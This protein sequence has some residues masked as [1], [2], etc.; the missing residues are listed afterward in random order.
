MKVLL[1]I[2]VSFL[3]TLV[4]FSQL[5]VCLVFPGLGKLSSANLQTGKPGI[6]RLLCNVEALI[7]KRGLRYGDLIRIESLTICRCDC[8]GR[9]FSSV[10]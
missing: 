7:V 6:V 10:F 8:K 5:V 4:S 1:F 2:S 3:I 9:M